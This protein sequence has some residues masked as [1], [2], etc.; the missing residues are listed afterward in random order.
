MHIHADSC[1]PAAVHMTES[2]LVNAYNCV[3]DFT[4]VVW[5]CASHRLQ[6]NASKTEVILVGSQW[7]HD[8]MVWLD[9]TSSRIGSKY[10]LAK[11]QY[12]DVT[13]TEYR[14]D[15]TDHIRCPPQLSSFIH[16]W[17]HDFCS[18]IT[19]VLYSNWVVCRW[20]CANS[21]RILF[22]KTTHCEQ[23]QNITRH[24]NGVIH[25]SLSVLVMV[26][27]SINYS[28]WMPSTMGGSQNL[29]KMVM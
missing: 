21:I 23:S 8:T 14:D 15:W 11:L 3:A 5:L 20:V 16:H 19:S 18:S 25:H 12:R 28:L 1:M 7:R 27:L 6:L 9:C 24:V 17:T 22:C 26:N 4:D 10:N 29:K 13:V 2:T